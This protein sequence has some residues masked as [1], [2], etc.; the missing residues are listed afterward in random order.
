MD[1]ARQRLNRALRDEAVTQIRQ[2]LGREKQRLVNSARG[3]LAI[4]YG[5][6]W[7]CMAV[8]YLVALGW[9]TSDLKRSRREY[10]NA[11]Q[12]YATRDACL[13]QFRAINRLDNTFALGE[14]FWWLMEFVWPG[15]VVVVMCLSFS[16]LVSL[17]ALL[18]AVW[19]LSSPGLAV[20]DDDQSAAAL[21]AYERLSALNGVGDDEGL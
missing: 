15:A 1:N 20:Y 8:Y 2:A 18:W 17:S 6:V 4:L 3:K 11:C 19:R 7:L 16:N 13:T 10:K 12:T 5:V 14:D 9:S 21:A